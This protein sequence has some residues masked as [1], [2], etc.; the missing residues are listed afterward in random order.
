MNK[1]K[2]NRTV[3]SSNVKRLSKAFGISRFRIL[4]NSLV[5]FYS[6]KAFA[7]PV[8]SNTPMD[9]IYR[10]K[11]K[12]EILT[13]KKI[14]KTTIK[15]P[16]FIKKNGVLCMKFKGYIYTPK[17]SG[18][19]PYLAIELNGKPLDRYIVSGGNRLINKALS[20]KTTIEGD[21]KWWSGGQLLTF[22][23]PGKGELD[24]RI[25]SSRKEGYWYLLDISDLANYVEVGPD[26]RIESRKCN[27]LT[28]INSL[29][30]R[31]KKGETSKA[32]NMVIE[33]LTFGYI[34][35]K[36]ISKS[37]EIHLDK[38]KPIEGLLLKGKDFSLT[39]SKTGGMQLKIGRDNYF[40]NSFFSYPGRTISYNTLTPSKADGEKSWKPELKQVSDKII[41]IT[42]ISSNYVLKRKLILTE[43]KISIEDKIT[44]KRDF[45]IGIIVRDNI[46]TEKYPEPKTYRLAGIEDDRI[47]GTSANPTIFV[48][49]KDSGVGI[50]AED[51]VFRIQLE[52][53]RINNTF[54]FVTK[55]FGLEKGK[56]YTLKWSIYPSKNKEY[57]YFVNQLRKD[58]NT[59]FTVLGPCAFGDIIYRAGRKMKIYIPYPFFE[60][61]PPPDGSTLTKKGYKAYIQKNNK[62]SNLRA[63]QPDAKCLG[64]LETNLLTI[65]KRKIKGGERL[66]GN[67]LRHRGT[68]GLALSKEQTAILL[69]SPIVQKYEDS[70]IRTADGRIVVDTNYASD[71]YIN[72]ML[73]VEEGNYRYKHFFEQID[74]MMDDVKMDGVYIDQFT[75]GG[76]ISRKDKHTD[77]KWDLHTVDIDDTGRI[78][79]KYTSCCL[80]GATARM[81]IIKYILNKGGIVVVNGH[82]SVK[83]T[84]NLPL[85]SFSE[86]END[87]INPLIYMH[88]KPP[89]FLYQAKGLLSSPIILGIRPKRLGLSAMENYAEIMTKAIITA[90]RNGMLYYYYAYV[91]PSSG[92]GAGDYGPTNH[93]F[94]FTPVE[95]HP[96]WLVGKER[97]ITCVSG[98]YQWNFA[99]EPVCHLFDLKGREK[100]NNF[101][102]I[103]KEKYYDIR[104]EI[105][106]WNEIAILE[107]KER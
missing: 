67:K 21:K 25:I 68:Y 91:I 105:S 63:A 60:Y 34:D 86:M 54:N 106:D 84:Q 41:E 55:H 35:K 59:N 12:I 3:L 28:F 72:L 103:K 80:V 57:F 5:L 78:K 42:A 64:M 104:V 87:A 26:G 33:D 62:L 13:T 19:N 16:C 40:F 51:N 101:K 49:Q 31:Y 94:P 85:F 66:P 27:T 4:L 75:F 38:Y 98:T 70:L 17:P 81:K 45:P 39:V 73:F 47:E 23:G 61:S 99:E 96:G 46:V 92:S 69:S 2:K 82:P 14:E 29:I 53:L 102:I 76:V 1:H 107:K 30:S 77:Y 71:P 43:R 11:R 8:P 24:K 22:F 32:T 9:V 100:K 95:L 48:T 83:E 74:F 90:I 36:L 18:W 65:D 89:V 6:I 97:I 37:R 15:I 7:A 44:N 50:V 20:C 88:K 10:E 79:K 58:W 56:E 93:M 52:L